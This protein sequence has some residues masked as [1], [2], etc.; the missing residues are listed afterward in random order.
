M[1]TDKPKREEMSTIPPSRGITIKKA[2][3][4]LYLKKCSKTVQTQE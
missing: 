1:S 3:E 4:I 2:C